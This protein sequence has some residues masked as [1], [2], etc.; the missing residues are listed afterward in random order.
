MSC[1]TIGQSDCGTETGHEC[2][3]SLK[4]CK[5]NKIKVCSWE[6]VKIG[7]HTQGAIT[8]VQLISDDSGGRVFFLLSMVVLVRVSFIWMLAISK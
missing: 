6:S 7:H 2:F 1:S 8:I 3:D 4:L 5:I